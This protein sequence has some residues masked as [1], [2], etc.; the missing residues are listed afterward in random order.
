MFKNMTFER[1]QLLSALDQMFSTYEPAYDMLRSNKQWKLSFP[2]EE[3][4]P[5]YTYDPPFVSEP[6]LPVGM[7]VT[8]VS[9]RWDPDLLIFLHEKDKFFYTETEHQTEVQTILK[10]KNLEEYKVTRP[11]IQGKQSISVTK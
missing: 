8:M 11:W 2:N 10:L 7:Y 3:S 6:G 4:G 5:C 9:D 1:I